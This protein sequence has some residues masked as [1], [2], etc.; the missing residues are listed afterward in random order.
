MLADLSDSELLGVWH[1]FVWLLGVWQLLVTSS[2]LLLV[3]PGA[4]SDFLLLC[5]SAG[6]VREAAESR[7]A[8]CEADSEADV[9]RRAFVPIQ[10]PALLEIEVNGFQIHTVS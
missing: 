8:E 6:R 5:F 4:P 2:Y 9:L 1:S 7:V 3:R 10:D